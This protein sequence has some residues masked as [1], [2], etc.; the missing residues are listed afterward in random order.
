MAS[1]SQITWTKNYGLFVLCDFNRDVGKIAKLKELMAREGYIGAYPLH[2]VRM[3]GKLHIKAGHHRFTAARELGIAVPYVVCEDQA[4]IFELEGA[5]RP[6]KMS[7]YLA[8]YVRLGGADYIE[9]QK[10]VKETGIS[11]QISALLMF[12]YSTEGNG[13]IHQVFKQGKF[14][15]KDRKRAHVVADI[16]SAF[17]SAGVKFASDT[18][19]VGAI[20]RATLADGFDSGRLCAKIKTFS[21][22]IEKQPNQE[23][24][25]EMLEDLYNRQARDKYPLAFMAD[26]AVKSRSVTSNSA[27]TNQKRIEGNRAKGVRVAV[28]AMP[29]AAAARLN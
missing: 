1:K 2:V 25:M 10:F 7:D 14:R 5:T 8:A 21:Q 13:R 28:P 16:V 26:Q 9:L 22:F 11:L 29:L 24:Y 17:A 19:L 20:A 12:G 27:E 18:L 3:N 4:T 15:V 23:R 6:W